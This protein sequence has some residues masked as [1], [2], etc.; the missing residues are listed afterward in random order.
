MK[1]QVLATWILH[2]SKRSND[3]YIFFFN[4]L[5]FYFISFYQSLISSGLSGLR[6]FLYFVHV[7]FCIYAEITIRVFGNAVGTWKII[8]SLKQYIT[9]LRGADPKKTE[10]FR[11]GIGYHKL[12][13]RIEAVCSDGFGWYNF[14]S[15][16][17]EPVRGVSWFSNFN[18]CRLILCLYPRRESFVMSLSVSR[19]RTG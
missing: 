14:V 16:I 8:S 2:H 13:N 11:S 1:K 15:S 4:L 17:P 10:P 12:K 18:I 6:V 3:L 9:L 19:A 7:Q 5:L